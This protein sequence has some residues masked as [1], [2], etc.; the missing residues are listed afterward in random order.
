MSVLSKLRIVLQN[1]DIIPVIL[2]TCN[3][4]HVKTILGIKKNRDM[5]VQI[6]NEIDYMISKN[7]TNDEIV[8]YTSKKFNFVKYA[9]I[10]YLLI[11][12]HHLKIIVETGVSMGWSSF[13]IL[14]ALQREGSGKLYSIDIDTSNSVKQDGGVGY[15]V[16]AHLKKYWVLEVG[17]TR[18][19]LKPI[20]SKL[21]KLDMFIHDSDHSY[22]VMSFEY[23]LAWKFLKKSGF[24]CSDDINHSDAFDEFLIK[25][26]NDFT[27][28]HEFQEIARPEDNVNKRPM[29]GFLQKN[30]A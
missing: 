8:K 21:G 7:N 17:D 10:W 18:K 19:L 3:R 14:T 15:M 16:P 4:Q 5:M 2:K 24:L 20:L 23:D 6:C 1:P 13:M 30:I 12:K 27:N 22:Q 11:R 28:L 26:K 29:I 25:H 9:I